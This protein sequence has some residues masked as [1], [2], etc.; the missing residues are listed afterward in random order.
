MQSMQCPVEL[1]VVEGGDHMLN[2]PEELELLVKAIDSL[3]SL[4][5]TSGQGQG[6]YDDDDD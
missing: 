3:L 6:D 1:K 5:S 2:R 4:K